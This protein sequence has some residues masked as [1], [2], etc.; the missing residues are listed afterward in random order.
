MPEGRCTS[1]SPP[2]E[3]RPQPFEVLYETRFLQQLQRDALGN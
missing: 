2:R 1:D 3:E